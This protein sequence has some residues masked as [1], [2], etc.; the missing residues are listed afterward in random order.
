[1]RK[2]R[3]RL[4]V[5]VDHV[6]TLRQA[7]GTTY[8]DVTEAALVCMRAGALGITVHLREDRRHIRDADVLRLR[9]RLPRGTLNLEMADVGEIVAFAVRI[10]P[11]EACLVPERRQERTTEGGLDV[12]GRA[13]AMARTVARLQAA[14]IEVSL[15]IEPDPGQI[16]AAADVGARVVELHAGRYCDARGAAARRELGRLTRAA[17]LAADLGLQVNAGH[18]IHTGNLPGILEMPHLH[19]LNIGHSIVSRAL[20]VG[21]RGAVRE[22]LA[23]MRLYRGGAA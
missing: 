20:F 19:T 11:D 23:G 16:R 4:G 15:F 13:R 21:L 10:R 8:P 9:A 1:M 2:R 5:N 14:G 22:M 18:G 6:A 7:R 12:R 17:G 3:L